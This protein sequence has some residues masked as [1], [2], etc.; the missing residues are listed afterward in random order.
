MG[1]KKSMIPGFSL[2]R[3]L[4]I[5]SAKQVISRATGIPTTKQGRKRKMQSTVWTAVAVGTA[6]A[7]SKSGK[8]D[9]VNDQTLLDESESQHQENVQ[10]QKPPKKPSMLVPIILLLVG[11][12]MFSNGL[13]LPAI[14]FPIISLISASKNIK[15][16]VTHTSDS[17]RSS[18]FSIS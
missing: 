8:S 10:N 1:R 3:A 6:A 16:T 17:P 11:F 15:K 12:I 14:I 7:I 13:Y 4:G 18:H 9:S 2:N 5:S